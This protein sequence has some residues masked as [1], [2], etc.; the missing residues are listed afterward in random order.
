MWLCNSFSMTLNLNKSKPAFNIPDPRLN[1]L[2]CRFVGRGQK[3]CS[4]IFSISSAAASFKQMALIF[5]SPAPKTLRSGLTNP[6]HS[7]ELTLPGQFFR[8]E[9]NP[10]IA[11]TKLIAN[12]A[13]VLLL[14]EVLRFD[15]TPVR[16][17]VNQVE[18]RT[19]LHPAAHEKT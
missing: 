8:T 14:C 4:S 12:N 19:L 17:D 15:R 10:Q 6:M 3:L 7:S 5:S 1:R 13:L 18:N 11:R 9:E 2:N 16:V